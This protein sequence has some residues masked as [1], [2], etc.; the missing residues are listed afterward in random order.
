LSLAG[1]PAVYVVEQ[2]AAMRDGSRKSSQP[3]MIAPSLMQKVAA[4]VSADEVAEAAAYF[5]SLTYKR[6]IRVVE[7][8]T[9]P[10]PEIHGVSAYAAAANGSQEPIGDR[11]VEVPEDAARGCSRRRLRLCSLCARRI[12]RARQGARLDCCRRTPA[13]RRLSG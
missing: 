3:A 7:T 1:L 12:H 2:I 13:L 6:W 10:R 9:V 4:R 8:D 5:A 11:I